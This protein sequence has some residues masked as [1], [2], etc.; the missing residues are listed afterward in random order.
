VNKTGP[1][2]GPAEEN[3]HLAG[4]GH[5]NQRG[6]ESITAITGWG[7]SQIAALNRKPGHL[8]HQTY[9]I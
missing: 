7:G 1:A 9:K 5:R 6:V 4:C 8:N 2:Q 3:A